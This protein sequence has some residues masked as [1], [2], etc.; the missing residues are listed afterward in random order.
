[1][2]GRLRGF[3]DFFAVAIDVIAYDFEAGCIICRG[4]V[5]IVDHQYISVAGYTSQGEMVSSFGHIE[6]VLFPLQ[7]ILLKTVT[8]LE[9]AYIC[10]FG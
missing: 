6:I 4:E 5:H 10:S 7:G 2:K 1:M 8:D 3:I 9:V